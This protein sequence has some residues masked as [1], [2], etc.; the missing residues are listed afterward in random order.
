MIGAA[1]DRHRLPPLDL[2]VGHG[3]VFSLGNV[4]VRVSEV[5][6]HTVGH[7]VFHIPSVKALFTADS[8]MA[9]GCGRLFEGTPEQMLASLTMLSD[10]PNDTLIYSG[11]EYTATNA[12]FA[13][14]VDPEN[15]DLKA[16][17]EDIATARKAG[18]P[19]VPSLLSLEKKTNPFLRSDSDGIRTALDMADAT[20]LEV[21]T[22]VRLRRNQF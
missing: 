5:P 22:E 11:H 9:L 8:L 15:A 7:I 6:G 13:L 12:A 19:T 2:E 10:L 3:T 14:T 17:S 21:F 16:R 1:A 4:D 20:E 18:Q